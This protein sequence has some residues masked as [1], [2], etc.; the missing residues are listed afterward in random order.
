MNYIEINLALVSNRPIYPIFKND[1]INF[2]EEKS[3]QMRREIDNLELKWI[4][5]GLELLME[6]EIVEDAEIIKNLFPDRRLCDCAC[7]IKSSTE[8]STFIDDKSKLF[9]NAY[10]DKFENHNQLEEIDWKEETK[11][12]LVKVIEKRIYDTM[13]A[14]NLAYPGMFEISEGNIAIDGNQY[15]QIPIINNS[16][17]FAYQELYEK[18]WPK[19]SQVTIEETWNWL[20]NKTSYL[21]EIGNRPIDKALNSLSYSFNSNN[22]ED[23]FYSL[24]GI[25]ALLNT[26]NS[27]SIMEQIRSK[28]VSL[29]GEPVDYRKRITK[30]Y[31][32]RSEFIHGKLSFP[33]KFH[34]NDAQ[35]KFEKFYMKDY[36]ETVYIAQSILI[37][38]IC[39]FIIK[40][41]NELLSN[42]TLQFK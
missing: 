25:E 39:E 42:I 1:F 14:I 37:S 3:S 17:L 36:K 13:L 18:R 28:T 20:M 30:M 23:F 2:L 34:I 32:R 8:L 21:D 10:N 38:I 24:L 35:E 6:F 40:D 9:I 22:Y 12:E 4:I 29:F 19:L 15:I 26:G 31:E 16:L 5:D 41:A 11:N 33:S 27:D 7:R